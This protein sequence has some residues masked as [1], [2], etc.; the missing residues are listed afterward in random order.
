MGESILECPIC[1]EEFKYPVMPP[2][3]HT[4]CFP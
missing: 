1:H 3:Q 4:F 2:C